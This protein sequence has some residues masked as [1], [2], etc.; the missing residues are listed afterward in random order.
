MKSDGL[1]L[2]ASLTPFHSVILKNSGRLSANLFYGNSI[3]SKKL[4][5]Y[6]QKSEFHTESIMGAERYLPPWFR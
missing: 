3:K 4:C 5:T 2:F 6:H 1:S